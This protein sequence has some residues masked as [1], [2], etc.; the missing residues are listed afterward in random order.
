MKKKRQRAEA[1]GQILFVR[2]DK[3]QS[4]TKLIF[5]EHSLE[6]FPSL[7]NTVTVIAV[8]NENDTLSVLEIMSPERSDLV[9]PTNIPDCELN[10]LVFY[11]LNVEACRRRRSSS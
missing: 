4:I 5:V 1:Y 11:S 8:N 9:L 7:D 2:K 10:V 3:Q 6:F